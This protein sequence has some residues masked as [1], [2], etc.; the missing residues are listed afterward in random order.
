MWPL[1]RNATTFAYMRERG[2]PSA[3]TLH[4]VINP[5]NRTHGTAVFDAHIFGALADVNEIA[6]IWLQSCNTQH[7]RKSFGGVSPLTCHRVPSASHLREAELWRLTG[8]VPLTN[9]G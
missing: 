1:A 5:F 8:S 9:H 7:P 6:H 3:G 4:A 2:N